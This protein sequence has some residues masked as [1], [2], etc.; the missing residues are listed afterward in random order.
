MGA[1]KY[2]QKWLHLGPRHEGP[3]CSHF[4][5]LLVHIRPE[6]STK[7][8]SIVH[9][10]WRHL[11]TCWRAPFP[12]CVMWQPAAH[13]YGIA[14]LEAQVCTGTPG[15]RPRPPPVT[16]TSVAPEARRSSNRTAS[17]AEWASSIQ[18]KLTILMHTLEM[19]INWLLVPL[20]RGGPAIEGFR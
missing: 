14:S 19:R 1:K 13:G 4:C 9:S 3:K 17:R 15:P 8:K 12:L 18:M 5:G 16:G 2:I 11:I 10:A 6:P 7:T 20:W